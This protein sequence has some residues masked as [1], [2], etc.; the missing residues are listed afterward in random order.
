ML[1]SVTCLEIGCKFLQAECTRDDISADTAHDN[2]VTPNEQ[3]QLTRS[4]ELKY[5]RLPEMQIRNVFVRPDGRAIELQRVM[6]SQRH[7]RVRMNIVRWLV[8]RVFGDSLVRA[9]AVRSR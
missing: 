2:D 8:T 5:P 7:S 9:V 1:Y 4:F 3:L 6:R